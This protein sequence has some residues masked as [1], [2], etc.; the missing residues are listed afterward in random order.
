M[1]WLIIVTYLI[2][3]F[4]NSHSFSRSQNHTG[5]PS[6]W[7]IALLFIY[8]L[9]HQSIKILILLKFLHIWSKFG[10]Y[11]KIR[12]PRYFMHLVRKIRPMYVSSSIKIKCKAIVSCTSC[13]TYC[14]HN[15]KSNQIKKLNSIPRWMFCCTAFC[16]ILKVSYQV[17]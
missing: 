4:L 5:T 12:T 10:R 1:H 7:C 17:K 14:T 9:L 13:I 16:L 8:Y 2:P 3:A 11:S 6:K 15:F